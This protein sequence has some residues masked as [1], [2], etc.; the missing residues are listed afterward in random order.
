M[1]PYRKI[2]LLLLMVSLP[3]K[4]SYLLA[5]GLNGSYEIKGSSKYGFFGTKFIHID[6]RQFVENTGRDTRNSSKFGWITQFEK[7]DSV[8]EVSFYRG[9]TNEWNIGVIDYHLYNYK[10]YYK[11]ASLSESGEVLNLEEVYYDEDAERYLLKGKIRE[12]TSM[13]FDFYNKEKSYKYYRVEKEYKISNKG[14]CHCTCPRKRNGKYSSYSIPDNIFL[15]NYLRYEAVDTNYEAINDLN[16][17]K[18]VDDWGEGTT[19]IAVRLKNKVDIE[20]LYNDTELTDKKLRAK[21][22]RLYNWKQKLIEEDK[23]IIFFDLET[24]NDELIVHSP[25]Y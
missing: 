20:I 5:L 10:M 6:D 22:Q 11:I 8:F 25:I 19:F 3:L 9:F 4:M 13:P 12:D 2:I 21:L 17:L 24:Y 16:K 1:T 23:S 14:G 7:S 15:S 18:V